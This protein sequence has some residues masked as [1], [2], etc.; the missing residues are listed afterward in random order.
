[1]KLNSKYLILLFLFLLNSC[2]DP[3][4]EHGVPG[5]FRLML[6]ND[7]ASTMVIGWNYYQG[8][9]EHNKFYYDVIDHGTDIEAYAYRA[10]PQF[11]SDY[12]KIQ[13]AFIELRNLEAKT[14][15]YFVVVNSQG[16]SKRYWFE[17]LSDSP[18]EPISIVAG[19][20]SR[21]NRE[22][23]L[24]ANLLVAK[25]RPHAVMFGGDMT[26]RGSAKQWWQWLDDWQA[27]I[28]TDGRMTPVLMTRGNHEKE[29]NILE[30]L[31]WTA[32]EVYYGVT[33]GKSLLRVYVLNSESSIGGN[34][35][36]WLK[37]DLEAH[38]EVNFKFAQY[39]RP[40]RPHTK[41][42][43]EGTNQYK[44]W[45]PLFYKYGMDLVV[46]SDSHMVKSTW[47]ISPSSSKDAEEGFVRDDENGT[48][49]VGEGCWG[50]PLR[51]NNDPKSWTRDIGSFNQFKWIHVYQNKIDIQT[52][53][54]DNAEVVGSINPEDV[55]TAPENLDVWNPNEG[56]ILT[57][58][59]RN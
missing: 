5:Q 54:I 46:E 16:V 43:K 44:F 53:K 2:F 22:P 57:I 6:R 45:A 52:I 58:N 55:F 50:A 9:R 37:E 15:Y 13:S 7:P 11:Y 32:Q 51:K 26:S 31:F 27:T 41:N 21:N 12:K 39:H 3:S 28:A 40:M 34:Q 38:K 24:K 29:N 14:K 20:D 48:V 8:K 30:K 19:G 25:L 10:I 56:S 18:V 17:T 47:P 59:A 36:I 42:K 35:T 33:F 49:Y 1:M 4:L 23:R